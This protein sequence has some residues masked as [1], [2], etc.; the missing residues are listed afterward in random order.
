MVPLAG[1]PFAR[2]VARFGPVIE[3]DH[4]Q[5]RVTRHRPIRPLP[6]KAQPACGTVQA[7][8][9]YGPVRAI[10]R[11]RL[12]SGL[13]Y[14]AFERSIRD[15]PAVRSAVRVIGDVDYELRLE[16]PD[17]AHLGGVLTSLRAC[18]GT[19]VAS[20]VLVTREV[21]GLGRRARSIADWGT[22]PR[23]RQTRSA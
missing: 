14:Q 6:A 1:V 3:S 17:L 22:A 19:E 21:E 5:A 10:A 18:R 20:T 11:I 4:A 16:C 2:G 9:A 23:P 7:Q 8:P 15:I 12:T 13:S